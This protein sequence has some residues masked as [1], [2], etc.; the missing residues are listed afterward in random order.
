MMYR[1]RGVAIRHTSPG[2]SPALPWCAC[3]QPCAHLYSVSPL[4][5][6]CE[7]EAA[8]CSVCA[9]H[10]QHDKHIVW[11]ADQRSSSLFFLQTERG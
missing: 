4:P 9:T 11:E 6:P 1:M 8:L 2:T 7:S 3:S 5:R 10:Q